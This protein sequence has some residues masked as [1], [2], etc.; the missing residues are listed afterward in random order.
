MTRHRLGPGQV[1]GVFGQ[2]VA[3][4]AALLKGEPASH[5]V[6]P[7]ERLAVR[8]SWAP[9]GDAGRAAEQDDYRNCY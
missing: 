2:R 7:G 4:A 5:V 1:Q 3:G 8:R 6:G 9:A